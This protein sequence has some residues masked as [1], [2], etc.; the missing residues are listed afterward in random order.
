MILDLKNKSKAISVT[1]LG[2]VG[3]PLALEFAKHFK[4]IGFDI[5]AERIALMKQNIDPSKELDSRAFEGCDIEFTSNPEDLKKAHFHIIGVPT[6]I[7]EHKVP[8]LKPL[9]G[10]SA[11]VGRALKQGD[12]VVYESTVY[13]GCTEEDCLPILEKE[14]KLKGGIDFKYGY[15]PERIVP[16]D[17]VRTLT[18]ILKIVSGCD[19]ETLEL[20][21]DV[22]CTII[23]AGVYKASSVKVAEAAKVIENTQ[24]DINISLMNELAI[25]FDK[26]GIDTNEV[27]EAAGSKWN[28][29]KYQPGLVGGHCIGVDPFYLMHKAKQIGH[30]PQVIA[31]GRRVNDYIPHFIAKRVVTTLIDQGKNPGECKVLVM[32]ITFKEDVSDIRNSKVADL[33]NEL[34]DYSMKVDVVDPWADIKEVHEEY[35][36]TM[37]HNFDSGYD[38]LILA[39]G[40]QEYRKLSISELKNLSKSGRVNLFDIKGVLNIEGLDFYWKL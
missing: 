30:D 9:L 31:A 4:V 25:I 20:I 32:G 28:F 11:S 35:G 33:I 8:N 1:G 38:A 36:I 5:N 26:I 40:H 21:S 2:Y 37:K 7:D 14:S 24:R 18:K 23:E 6:D 10:A 13:P 17:K 16:G 12:V 29:H 19:Q 15:S 34:S 39:V 22:Y 3:L 27:I